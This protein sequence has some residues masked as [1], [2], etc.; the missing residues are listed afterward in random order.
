MFDLSKMSQKIH[1]SN[2]TSRALRSFHSYMEVLRSS[3]ANG[4]PYQMD[5]YVKMTILHTTQKGEHKS[6]HFQILNC[7]NGGITI[8]LLNW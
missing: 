7:Q 2:K 1:V 8:S 4:Q 3:A 5:L 6:L